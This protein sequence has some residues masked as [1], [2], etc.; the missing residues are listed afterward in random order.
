MMIRA[1]AL[2]LALFTLPVAAA[3][4]QVTMDYRLSHNG[5]E[6]GVVHETYA[7]QGNHYRIDS[8]TS[9][10]GPLAMLFKGQLNSSSEGNVSARGLRPLAFEQIRSDA[11][12]KNLSARFDWKTGQVTHTAKGRS[13]TTALPAGTQDRLS[14]LY[15]FMFVKPGSKT[16]NFDVSS[17]HGLYPEVYTLVAKETLTT[18]AGKFKTLHYRNQPTQGEKQIEVW[19]ARDQHYLPAQVR[20][21]DDGATALQTLIRIKTE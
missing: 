1:L 13:E 18:P 4:R 17:G 21:V 9:A 11:P 12:K 2:F 15:Q 10:V 7:R 8:Q 3:P 6:V 16:L 20:I 14:I 19:L 5:L